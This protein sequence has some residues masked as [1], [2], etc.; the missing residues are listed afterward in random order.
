M[1]HHEPVIVF[2]VVTFTNLPPR[3]AADEIDA[4]MDDV[5]RTTPRFLLVAPA[6]PA[7]VAAPDALDRG[8]ERLERAF[9][10][11]LHAVPSPQTPRRSHFPVV[12]LQPWRPAA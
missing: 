9:A 6:V 10:E 5:S 8:L 12:A 7:A 4:W 3:S 2:P 1:A 11:T